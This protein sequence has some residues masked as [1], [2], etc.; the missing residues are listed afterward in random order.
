MHTINVVIS[1][2]RSRVIRCYD[3]DHVYDKSITI[4]QLSLTNPRDALHHG[5]RQTFKSHVTT[6]FSLLWVICHPVARIDVAYMCTKFD[7]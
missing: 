6:T 1:R 5:K 7:D 2:K 3:T 4:A